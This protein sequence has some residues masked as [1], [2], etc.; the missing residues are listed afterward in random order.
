MKLL[1]ILPTFLKRLDC[2]SKDFLP[3][4]MHYHK[5]KILKNIK[6]QKVIDGEEI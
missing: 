5:A 2:P 4:H 3:F 6:N 1:L